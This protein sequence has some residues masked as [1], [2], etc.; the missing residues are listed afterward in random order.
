[1]HPADADRQQV[2]DVKYCV[3]SSTTPDQMVGVLL[4]GRYRVERRL[5]SGGMSQVYVGH[6]ERLDRPVAIKIMNAD[7]ASD[8]PFIARFTREARAAARVLHPNIVTV[9]DQGSDETHNAVYLVMELVNGGTLRDLLRREGTLGADEA[10]AIV[11]PLLMGLAAAHAEGLVHRDVKPENILIDT[12]GRVLVADFGLARAVAESSHTTHSGHAGAVFG[13]I[14]YLS[15]EQVTKGYADA[16]SDVYAAGILLYEMLTGSP[17][18]TGDNAVSVAYRHVNDD[19]PPPSDEISEIP[20]EVD[21]LVIAATTRDPLARP[22]DAGQLLSLVRAARSELAMTD[23]AVPAVDPPRVMNDP[24]PAHAAQ[25]VHVDSEAARDGDTRDHDRELDDDDS[26][27]FVIGVDES[28]S[29]APDTTAEV[30]PVRGRERNRRRWLVP[31]VLTVVLALLAGTG[32]WWMQYGRWTE[33]PD[34][35]TA[36]GQQE[37]ST[38]ASEAG[39]DIDLQPP[40]YSETV[41]E[42]VPI[43]VDPG[44][45]TRVTRGTDVRIVLSMG[46]E[47]YVIDPQFVGEPWSEVEPQISAL[48][49]DRIAIEVVTDY[50]ELVAKESVVEMEPAPGTQLKPGQTLVVTVSEGRNPIPIPDVAG[51]SPQEAQE[52]LTDAGFVA[53]VSPTEEF[54]DET[55]G[56]VARTDPEAGTDAQPDADVTITVVISKGPD[57]V[58]VPSVTGLTTS[59]ATEELEKAG[60]DVEVSTVF[61]TFGLVAV[62]SPSGGTMA[63]RGSTITLK[64]V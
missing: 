9:H 34:F 27:D 4:D 25:T 35:T 31:L 29:D 49:G 46:P 51:Q 32:F 11:E 44:P 47:R 53:S 20:G 16:R 63:K 19:V 22:A 61:T 1:M 38:L 17:P 28:D 39:V 52:T 48:V 12:K 14:A 21:D 55:A 64:I 26:D 40:Q 23:V 54:S 13:T 50:S 8:P 43:E 62:Q 6:D 45:G 36:Q 15:P 24:A 33:V 59:A 56:T 18:Y 37:V 41:A 57:L 60:F 2:G 30:V 58:E 3:V 42:G 5:A 10:L 7:L